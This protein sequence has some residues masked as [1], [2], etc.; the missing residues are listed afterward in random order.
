[1]F[2]VNILDVSFFLVMALF[3]VSSCVVEC[4]ENNVAMITGH[5]K[6]F[7]NKFFV[8]IIIISFGRF[9]MPLQVTLQTHFGSERFFAQIT[10]EAL[11]FEVFR[12]VLLH[13]ALESVH[14][15][16]NFAAFAAPTETN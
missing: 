12:M 1:M 3:V 4:G 15:L 16:I 8:L 9:G 2:I 13:V 6:I 10:N 7:G 11:L 14:R 5:V